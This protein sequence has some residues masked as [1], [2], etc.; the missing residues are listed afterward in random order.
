MWENVAVKRELISGE[1]R[2]PR[3]SGRHTKLSRQGE[4]RGEKQS[5]N[6]VDYFQDDLWNG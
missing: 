3:G 4:S 5:G 6:Q 1:C 2:L